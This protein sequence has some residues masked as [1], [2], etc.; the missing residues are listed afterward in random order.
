MHSIC[1]ALDNSMVRPASHLLTLY[2]APVLGAGLG[3]P[4]A[5]A[6][7]PS[8]EAHEAVVNITLAKLLHR[9]HM[10]LQ[11]QNLE[12]DNADERVGCL[13]ICVWGCGYRVCGWDGYHAFVRGG[14]L[15]VAIICVCV[16][17]MAIMAKGS[18]CIELNPPLKEAPSTHCPHGYL[19][20]FLSFDFLQTLHLC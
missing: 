3:V 5:G 17:G 10:V 19:G 4:V 7:H 18:R 8:Y 20:Q 9:M 13:G 15:S 1:V 2:P 11:V 6:T 14:W 12:G 16:V